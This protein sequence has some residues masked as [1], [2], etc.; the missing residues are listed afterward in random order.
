MF[1]HLGR[2]LF[3]VV[4]TEHITKNHGQSC[5]A[6]IT[7]IKVLRFAYTDTTF[8]TW[9]Y[10][11]IHK[12]VES[13]CYLYLHSKCIFNDIAMIRFYVLYYCFG[14]S[15]TSPTE[16]LMCPMYGGNAE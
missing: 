14:I 11:G 12:V 8:H 16:M 4:C 1:L 10:P 7:T 6:K 15:K 5:C 3:C 9:P 13:T 2:V